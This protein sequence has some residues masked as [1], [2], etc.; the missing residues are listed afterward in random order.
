MSLSGEF[1]FDKLLVGVLICWNGFVLSEFSKRF[2]S[3]IDVFGVSFG[4]IYNLVTYSNK[5]R[6]L[7]N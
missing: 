3:L 1:L 2:D 4:D 7:N 6:F 5:K